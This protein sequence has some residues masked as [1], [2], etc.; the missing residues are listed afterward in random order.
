MFDVF[1]WNKN[2]ETGIHEIDSQHKKLVLL[3]NKLARSLVYEEELKIDLALADLADYATYHFSAEEMVW[4]K[5]FGEDSWVSSHKTQHNEFMPNILKIKK[6]YPTKQLHEAVED[7]VKFLIRWLAF[8]ILEEDKRF[9]MVVTELERGGKFQPSKTKIEKEM[10]GSM[11]VLIE[12]ILTMY[13]GLSS[14][15]IE[16]MRE[17]KARIRAE[18]ELIKVNKKLEELSITDSLTGLFNRR[19]L[20]RVFKKELKRAKR[21]SGTLTYI[22]LDIDKFKSFNDTYGHP[23]GD[24]A[25]IQVAE[26]LVHL[27]RRPTDHAFRLG[28]EEFVV[29]TTGMTFEQSWKYCDQ[30]RKKIED[31]NIPHCHSEFNMVLTASIGFICR[32]PGSND[33]IDDFFNAADERLYKAKERGKNRIEGTR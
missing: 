13:D 9:A 27:C 6:N 10:K 11:K 21:E 29:L 33:S 18:E 19:F 28:G 1:P 5:Y 32:S 20:N 17:R 24:R 22:L 4:L 30:I 15:A 16:M 25:I 12:T 3:L 26:A 23:K 14:N 7:I 31:L 2:F 8:H